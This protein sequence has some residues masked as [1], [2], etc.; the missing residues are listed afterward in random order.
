[1]KI[2]TVTAALALVAA[3]AMTTS[4]QPASDDQTAVVR[5]NNQFAADLYGQLGQ[6]EGNLFFSPYSISSA[7]AMTYVGARGQ[8]ATDMAKTLHFD[9]DRPQLNDGWSSLNRALRGTDVKRPYQLSVANALWTQKGFSFLPA[10]KQTAQQSYS[11]GL[12]EVDYKGSTEAARQTINR[13]VEN[14]TK[15]KIKDLIAKGVL[16]SDTRLVL[17]NAIYFKAPWMSTFHEPATKKED[18]TLASGDKVKTPMMHQV[19]RFPYA[20]GDDFQLVSLPYERGDLSFVAILPKKADG[21]P[22][23]EKKMNAARLSD[24][25]G[26]A[27]TREVIL[28]LPK[29]KMTAQANLN[30]TLKAL[31][32]GIAFSPKA[33]FTGMSTEDALSISDVIHKAYIDLNEKGTEAAAATAV[34]VGVTSAIIPRPEERVTFR[35]DHPFQFVIRENRTGSI[36]FMGRLVNP[37]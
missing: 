24:L 36:L 21:L 11:A 16:T 35:A 25:L 5:G 37:Q 10:F 19:H 6:K 28:T 32:M 26:K 8:T 12:H 3:L 29:F 4:A 22:A 2:A 30:K 17:T 14:E 23:L 15:D 18:F 7:L 13:W 33:D 9:L 31:G 34:V 1:M 20:E 27:R